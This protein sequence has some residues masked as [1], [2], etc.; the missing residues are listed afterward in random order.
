MPG[1]ATLARFASYAFCVAVGVGALLRADCY[2]GFWC[3]A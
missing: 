2:G 3:L 1:V